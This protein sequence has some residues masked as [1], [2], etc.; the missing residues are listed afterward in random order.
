MD[1]VTTNWSRLALSQR[2]TRQERR[3]FPRRIPGLLGT[4]LDVRLAAPPRPIAVQGEVIN[5]HIRCG[6]CGRKRNELIRTTHQ[7]MCVR[8]VQ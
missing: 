2:Q 7:F 4:I 6:A 3:D 1:Y 8:C 5:G